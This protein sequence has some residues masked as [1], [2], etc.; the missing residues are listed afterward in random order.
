MSAAGNRSA[1][2]GWAA[3]G[4]AVAVALSAAGVIAYVHRE[5]LFPQAAEPAAEDPFQRCITE[6]AA[7]IDKMAADGVID[8]A[9]AALFKSRAE[10]LCRAPGPAQ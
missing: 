2:D 9:Q 3:K 4:I 6:R 5:T 8:G 1:L 7:E 10:A